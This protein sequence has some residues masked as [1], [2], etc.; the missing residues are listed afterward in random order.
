MISSL[1]PETGSVVDYR[2]PSLPVEARVESLLSQMTLDEKLQQMLMTD[3]ERMLDSL[4]GKP[5]EDALRAKIGTEGLGCLTDARRGTAR[6]SAEVTNALQRYLIEETRL[7]IPA[8]IMAECL[9]G[10][11]SPRATV[12]PQSIAVSSAWNPELVEK[13]AA[14]AAR[15][16]RAVGVVQALSPDLDVVR[17]PRWGRGE[18]TY[19]EDPFLIGELGLA[20]IKGMQGTEA[21][22]GSENLLC[23]LKH[24]AAH[25]SPESGLNLAPV[26]A[27]ER[28]LHT[29]YLPPFRK[30]I[31]EG[32]PGCVM[33][34]YSELDGVP[35][36][37]SK[38]LFSDILR[39]AW[40]FEGYVMSDYSSIEMLHRFHSVAASPG[41]AG[42]QAITCG[43]DLEAPSPYG[44]GPAL[45]EQIVNGLVDVAL[46]DRAVSRILRVKFLSGLFER[47]YVQVETADE[48]VSS[49]EHRQLALEL[50]RE[51]I[52][53][54]KNEGGLLPL[55]RDVKSI[56]VVGPNADE[57]QFGDYTCPGDRG[58][59]PLAAIRELVA[60][61]TEVRYARGCDIGNDRRDGFQEAIDAALASD[62]V[63]VVVGESSHWHNGKRWGDERDVTTC[64]E[65][66]DVDDL[67]LPGV[68]EELVRAIHATGKPVVLVLSHGRPNTVEWMSEH[69]PAILETWYPGE[70]GG[71]ALAEI[72]F[73]SVNP[74]GKLTVSVPR[75]TG[76]VPCYYNHKPSAKGY[77]DVP[78]SKEQPGRDYVFASPAARYGFG[79]GLSYTTFAYENLQ[80]SVV[81]S[82]G[83]RKVQV[84]VDV[85]NTGGCAGREVVQV[86]LRDVFS[87][88]TTPVRRLRAFRKITLEASERS[89]VSFELGEEDLQI[90]DIDMRWTVEPGEF[91]VMVGSLVTS[92]WIEK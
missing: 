86:Y 69:V 41:E 19:G 20:Y 53:L 54:L 39:E 48:I 33:T 67:Q 24:F 27:G 23:T 45:K 76:Q 42:K 37:A 15:E 35:S 31:I 38:L 7:G 58:I 3:F 18:E 73:G 16:A 65:G 21:Q 10:H 72:L 84:T 52:I 77:Y 62:V 56:A 4:D 74:S 29:A 25:G 66:F 81:S 36:T 75:S 57:C 83:C 43:V 8:L 13:M 60:P 63:V 70:M 32:K 46:V 92:F 55:S 90:L 34:A 78:G 49:P 82:D 85:S 89:S 44:F 50:A 61:S 2:D 9:H 6:E 14:A 40:G 80:A 59:T 30:A 91:Q 64:G 22:L 5:L 51:S 17:E 12:F 71:Q 87:S 68:Q 1:A 11:L 28:E 88:V 47:P 79:H 26:L